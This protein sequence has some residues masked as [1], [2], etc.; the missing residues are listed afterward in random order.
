MR[1]FL[2]LQHVTV[3]EEVFLALVAVHSHHAVATVALARVQIA[4]EGE[5]A[6]LVAVASRAAL[7][8]ETPVIGQ[9][10]VTPTSGHA[11]FALT[12]TV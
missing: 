8:R 11:R 3:V 6:R 7:G 9:A 12:L 1:T 10:L 2:A 5:G 4:L